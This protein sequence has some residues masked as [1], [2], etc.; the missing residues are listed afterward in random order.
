MAVLAYIGPGAGFAFFGSFL[1]LVTSLFLTAVSFFVWPFRALLK[2]LRRKQGFR[3]ARIQRLIFLGLDGLDPRLT[4]RYMDAGKL[5]NLARLKAQGSFHKLRTTFPSL[6]PV[7][8]STFA[9]GVN[10]ARHNIFDFLNRS[11][12]S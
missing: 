11:L 7:A 6:S 9:T 4:E 5:P 8:W 3:K 2:L 10:P 1:G 12:K